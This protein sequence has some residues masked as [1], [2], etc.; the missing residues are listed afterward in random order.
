MITISTDYNIHINTEITFNRIHGNILWNCKC[1]W[2]HFAWPYQFSP[3]HYS[4]Q[5][6][7]RSKQVVQY[8]SIR[9]ICVLWDSVFWWVLI[10]YF[11]WPYL[12]TRALSPQSKM[13]N[14][15]LTSWHRID[16]IPIF[17]CTYG[18]WLEQFIYNILW[19]DTFKYDLDIWI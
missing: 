8:L 4:T 12:F 13:K 7:T 3:L 5:S 15:R 1:C 18:R 9:C 2:L 6:K 11:A 17:D 10:V 19:Y 14:Q 16:D